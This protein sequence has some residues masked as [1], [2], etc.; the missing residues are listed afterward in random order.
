MCVA[1]PSRWRP[2]LAAAVRPLLSTAG[3]VVVYYLLP[4]NRPLTGSAFALLAVGLVVVIGVVVWQVR[5][6]LRSAHPAAQGVQ[7]LA[8]I[9]PLFLLVFASVYYLMAR[10]LPG[11]FSE[12]LTR[13]DA[14]YFTVTVFATVGF[15]DIVA[16]TE[17]A[18]IVVTT[19]MLGD[20]LVLGVLLRVILD[21]VQ[22]RRQDR[23]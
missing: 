2:T 6:I 22:R 3:L 1:P 4:M 5:A 10:D 16:L 14:L 13:T 20:L 18:R 7:A 11:S 15:G 23:T 9:I 12:P 17:A 21:A 8:V 19:Q